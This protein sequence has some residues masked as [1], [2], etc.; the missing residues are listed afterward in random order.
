M[1][2]G[3][4]CHYF[5]FDLHQTIQEVKD[6]EVK[7]IGMTTMKDLG[8]HIGEY[9]ADKKIDYVHLYGDNVYSKKIIE[10]NQPQQNLQIQSTEQI[11]LI[12]DNISL[13][14]SEKR[15]RKITWNIIS[16]YL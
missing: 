13:F 8:K 10:D 5:L 9:C 1:R 12:G 6:G 14:V 2:D 7:Q 15:K 4:I 16:N 11:K 3:I